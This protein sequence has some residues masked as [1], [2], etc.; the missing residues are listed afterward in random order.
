MGALQSKRN[1]S[2][3]SLWRGNDVL[4]KAVE[5]SVGLPI[6]SDSGVLFIQ[7]VGVKEF[8][9]AYIDTHTGRLYKCVVD[10]TTATNNN[11]DFIPLSL[12]EFD[13]KY[14]PAIAHTLD[15]GIVI[16]RCG[17]IQGI[18]F[19]NSV[20]DA[21]WTYSKITSITQAHVYKKTFAFPEWFKV[22]SW[23]SEVGI[24]FS[25]SDIGIY[26]EIMLRK[27]EIQIFT[28]NPL[29]YAAVPSANIASLSA[30]ATWAT[31]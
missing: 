22:P 26:G 4:I 27:T 7:D 31:E 20:M 3:D 14:R 1:R 5:A 23:Y 12:Q 18:M 29:D 6:G 8:A 2:I 11:A 9:H 16:W 13:A 10:S 15:I 30:C 25:S 19:T 24:P 28:L 21:S 17:N